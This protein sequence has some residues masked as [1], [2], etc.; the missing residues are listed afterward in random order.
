M[1]NAILRF[2]GTRYKIESSPVNLG[3]VALGETKRFKYDITNL[4]GGSIKILGVANSCS[5]TT[6]ED[7]PDSLP[8]AEQKTLEVKYVPQQDQLGKNYNSQISLFL[9]DSNVRQLNLGFSAQV[10]KANA[11]KQSRAE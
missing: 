2:Q 8:F 3:E 1:T 9:N 4:V 7:R 5:C 6:I 11:F 10:V